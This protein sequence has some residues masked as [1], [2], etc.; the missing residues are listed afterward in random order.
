[1]CH[2]RKFG[3]IF[4]SRQIYVV[5]RLVGSRWHICSPDL[6]AFLL[7]EGGKSF[8]LIIIKQTCSCVAFKMLSEALE[9]CELVK[10]MSLCWRKFLASRDR[11][12]N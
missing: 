6:S 10:V 7:C 5:R 2:I 9:V 1:M 4:L 8:T 11:H 3:G 12:S